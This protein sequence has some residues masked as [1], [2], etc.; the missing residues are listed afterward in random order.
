MKKIIFLKTFLFIQSLL[1]AQQIDYNKQI[2]KTDQK[3]TDYLVRIDNYI[4]YTVNSSSSKNK[5]NVF[6][7]G[8][9]I[10]STGLSL[11]MLP[12][13]INN[14][15]YFKLCEYDALNRTGSNYQ[16]FKIANSGKIESVH[17]I[18][19]LMISP[20]DFYYSYND[21]VIY[22]KNPLSGKKE[23]L[24]DVVPDVDSLFPQDIYHTFYKKGF[25]SLIRIHYLSPNKILLEFADCYGSCEGFAYIIYDVF[26]KKYILID[27]LN[28]LQKKDLDYIEKAFDI[29]RPSGTGTVYIGMIDLTEKYIYGDLTNYDFKKFDNDFIFNENIDTVS[30]ALKKVSYSK[31]YNYDQGKITSV[32]LRSILEN[33][34]EVFVPYR[35]T[36]PLERS[37]YRIYHNQSILEQDQKEFGEYEW[38]ILKNFIYAKHNYQFISEFYQA[39]F[40]VFEFYRAGIGKRRKE[41][42]KKYTK[43][44]K[45]NLKLILTKIK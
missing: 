36:L 45:E 43:A 24:I 10:D 13:V 5:K 21:S 9:A 15:I 28:N 18:P 38:S 32:M 14:T 19:N 12:L 33:Q 23:V 41:V 16:T 4:F 8:R 11:C 39:Y 7:N 20:S 29:S 22:K 1:Y 3:D 27:W 34:T 40:N 37:L 42:D 30:R 31:N 44:D 25:A 17:T 2:Y 35:F 6:L 26:H